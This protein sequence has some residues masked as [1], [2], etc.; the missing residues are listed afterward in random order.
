MFTP[1]LNK[2]SVHC[3]FSKWFIDYLKMLIN[4]FYLNCLIYM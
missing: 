3:D 1:V 2:L 4:A